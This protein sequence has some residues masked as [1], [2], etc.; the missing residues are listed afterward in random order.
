MRYA[1]P[2]MLLVAAGSP[3]FAADKFDLA[4]KGYKWTKLGGSGEAYSFH[5]RIDLAAQKWCDGDCKTTQSIVSTGDKELVLTDDGT[6]N[7]RMEVAHEATFDRKKNSFHYKMLQSRPTEQ[8]LEYQAD[9][10]MEPFTP[11]PG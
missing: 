5:V 8:Y 11:F 7:S 10:T 1:L 9:C 4:C 6:L 3:A 2:F